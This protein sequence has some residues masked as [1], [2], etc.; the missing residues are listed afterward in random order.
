MPFQ[1][2]MAPFQVFWVRDMQF[3]AL[4]LIVYRLSLNEKQM[5]VVG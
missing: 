4:V 1:W 5:D 3:R 2:D